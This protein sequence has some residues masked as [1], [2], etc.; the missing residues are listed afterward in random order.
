MMKLITVE[1]ELTASDLEAAM[2]LIS[3]QAETVLAMPGCANYA[4]YRKPSDDGVAI[5]QQWDGM[6]A[7]ETYRASDTFAALGAG[8]RPLMSK[9]PVTTVAEVDT[10]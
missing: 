1:A 2:E 5:I 9:P 4:L 3:G 7:V 10:V 8:L 6:E